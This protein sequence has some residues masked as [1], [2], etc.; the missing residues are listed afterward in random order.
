[1]DIAYNIIGNQHYALIYSVSGEVISPSRIEL[2]EISESY[3]INKLI[4][5]NSI[6]Q[7]IEVLYED[8]TQPSE[9]TLK[10]NYPNPFNP[11]TSIDII[12]PDNDFIKLAVYDISGNLVDII[13][14]GIYNAGSYTFMWDGNNFNGYPVASG[15]YIYSLIGSSRIESKRMILLK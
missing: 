13:A 9:F 6:N 5:V 1:M 12:I 2:F 7:I 14:E 11:V 15:M 10:Q 4:L 8:E 3:R